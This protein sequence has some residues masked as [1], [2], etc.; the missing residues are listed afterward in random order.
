MN[1]LANKEKNLN[2][3]IE[4]ISNLSES[5]SHVSINSDKLKIER[6]YFLNQKNELEKLSSK[7]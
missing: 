1:N 4:K 2:Q 6:D 5:Y 7:L 3:L